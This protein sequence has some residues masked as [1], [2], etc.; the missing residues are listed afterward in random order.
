MG[1]FAAH[2][3]ARQH[4][5]VA[6]PGTCRATQE[7]GGGPDDMR[8]GRAGKDEIEVMTAGCAHMRRRE[9]LKVSALATASVVGGAPE[10]NASGG[11]REYQ[12]RR[13]NVILVM[14]DDQGYGDL[15][16]HGN[17]VLRTPNLDRLHAES[18]RFTDFHVNPFCAPTRASL[19]T[20]KLSDRVGVHR[21]L[22]MRNYLPAR[23]VTMADV[24]GANGYRTGL[25][26]KWHL[27]HNYPYRPI[28]RGFDEWLGIGDCGLAATSDY[29]GN[30]RFDDHYNHNGQWERIEGFNTDV[31]F[32]RAM[33]FI[34]R[35]RERPFFIYL[36]PNVPHFPWNVRAE[37]L[38]TYRGRELPEELDN[39]Y[40]SI[41][42]VDENMGRLRRFLDAE[43]LADDTILIFLTDNGTAHGRNVY[44]A[45]MRARKGSVYE[46]GH[47]VPCIVH[48]PAGSLGPPR[49]IDTLVAHFDILPTLVDLCSLRLPHG[50]DLDGRSL[51][52]LLRSSAESWDERSWVLHSQNNKALPVKWAN[53]VVLTQR[54]RLIN[55]R[56]L[57]DM[58]AD[59][60]EK[61]DVAAKH[62][63][64]VA[65]LRRQYERH[66]ARS[67]LGSTRPCERP[68]VGS[69]QQ[70][71]VELGPDAWILDS[72]N[73]H[74]WWQGD[75]RAGRKVNGYWPILVA[76]PG[77]YHFEVRRWPV[78]VDAPMGGVP[79]EPALDETV[80]EQKRWRFPKCRALP[81]AAV[82]LQLSGRTLERRVGEGEVAVSFEARLEKGPMD[83]RATLL[84]TGNHEICG[85][86]FVYVR[87]R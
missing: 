73:E 53:S 36:A 43:G 84:D 63:E 6:V 20:G 69:A 56:Q 39:F 81:V 77:R 28:D 72:A 46:G 45:G 76:R 8:C 18:V 66:W 57:Y 70:R 60:S 4:A 19:M 79:G 9:F 61:S 26:G 48:W 11:S 74:I 7:V 75:V 16:C 32:D 1:A 41:A 64:V 50:S 24:L 22:N 15:S 34:R 80:V 44:N 13:P 3:H 62:P 23:E 85:A 71:V 2:P 51:A 17:P 86:Y 21:T 35:G 52:P 83:V 5:S 29:W 87:R 40:A 25:F 27:G 49:D 12:S 59:P 42:R 31:F 55:G 37:W 38:E 78:G 47:R 33:Q 10:A 58:R 68:V 82:R 65:E 67:G 14:T 54:W 30:D